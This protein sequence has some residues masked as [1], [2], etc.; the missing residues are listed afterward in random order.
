MT[1]QIRGTENEEKSTG[2]HRYAAETHW[3]RRHHPQ[4]HHEC[5]FS[6]SKVPKSDTKT[7]GEI[8]FFFTVSVSLS[9][10]LRIG[11]TSK[12]AARS[13]TPAILRGKGGMVHLVGTAEGTRQANK[14][15]KRSCSL[16]GFAAALQTRSVVLPHGVHRTLE[17]HWDQKTKF[18][19]QNWKLPKILLENRRFFWKTQKRPKILPE[20]MPFWSKH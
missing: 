17:V 19:R 5:F 14:K 18:F 13:E 1:V 4:Q 12:A 7:S 6:V 2:P 10:K 8:I 15:K 3:G 11:H 16:G 9:T 20:K